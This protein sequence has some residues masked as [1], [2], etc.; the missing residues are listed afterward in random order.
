[1]DIEFVSIFSEVP[2]RAC[3]MTGVSARKDVQQ[4]PRLVTSNERL[5]SHLGIAVLYTTDF[6]ELLRICGRRYF[7]ESDVEDFPSIT[8]T[9]IIA[10]LLC[11]QAWHI[12]PA[13]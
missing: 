11:V 8:S 3:R 7:E 9:A 1:M 5:R 6:V 2:S 4:N 10:D 12:K 13:I